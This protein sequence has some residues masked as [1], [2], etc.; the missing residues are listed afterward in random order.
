MYEP[1]SQEYE[2]CLSI[3]KELF[4]KVDNIS[5]EDL[6]KMTK[7][8]LDT[9]YSIGGSYDKEIVTKIAKAMFGMK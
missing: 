2:Q 6:N 1:T 9:S 8:I 7:D 3:V 5:T 4:L